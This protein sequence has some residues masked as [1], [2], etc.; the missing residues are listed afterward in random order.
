MKSC[1]ATYFDE[2]CQ[3]K[4]LT[5]SAST[6]GSYAYLDL[7]G[8]QH[9]RYCYMIAANDGAEKVNIC[10]MYAQQTGNNYIMHA[11]GDFYSY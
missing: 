7:P 11:P 2:Y 3:N 9:K 6:T 8:S 10:G 5:R 4:V 1:N